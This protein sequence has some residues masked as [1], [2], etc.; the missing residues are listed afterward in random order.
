MMN[1]LIYFIKGKHLH[2]LMED[3]FITV[4]RLNWPY[5][6]SFLKKE[7]HVKAPLIGISDHLKGSQVNLDWLILIG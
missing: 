4:L 5:L 6:G 2:L 7:P 1:T 3:H